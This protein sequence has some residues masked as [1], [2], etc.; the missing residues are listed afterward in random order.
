[1]HQHRG[2]SGHLSVHENSL[3]D[4][5]WML[6]EGGNAHREE[7]LQHP[8]VV[9]LQ[10]DLVSLHGVHSDEVGMLLIPLSVR[11]ALQQHQNEFQTPGRRAE[12]LGSGKL[13]PSF[14]PGVSKHPKNPQSQQR[15]PLAEVVP[16]PVCASREERGK[17]WM[18]SPGQDT[19][20][21]TEQNLQVKV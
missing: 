10:C 6:G 9:F 7:L 4:D 13:L 2:V 5:G 8:A 11:D 12:M 15:I 16:V 1:M 3:K 21:R 19:G 17:G 20:P 14:Q 18:E